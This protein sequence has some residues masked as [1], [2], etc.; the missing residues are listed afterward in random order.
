MENKYGLL[1]GILLLCF[2][3][4]SAQQTADSAQDVKLFSQ[5]N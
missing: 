5:G 1:A 2:I 3:P 4:L